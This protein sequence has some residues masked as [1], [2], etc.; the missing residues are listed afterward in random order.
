MQ[1][2]EPSA[3]LVHPLGNEIGR[4]ILFKPLHVVE[5]VVHL[6]VRHCARVEPDINQVLFAEHLFTAFAH[7]HDLIHEG[8]VQVQA[9]VVLVREV[10]RHKVRERILLHEPRGNRFFYLVP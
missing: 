9:A 4:K 3:C 1:R 7:Q 10:P 6:C 8:P 2:V 5:R